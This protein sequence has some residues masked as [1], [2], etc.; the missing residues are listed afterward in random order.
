[1][2]RAGGY[3]SVAASGK[4][5]SSVHP[6]RAFGRFTVTAANGQPRHGLRWGHAHPAQ[7]AAVGGGRKARGL[8]CS[9]SSSRPE[10]GACLTQVV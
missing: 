4:A 1:M 6:D 7:D 5:L 2:G 10:Q 8:L 3:V 9:P